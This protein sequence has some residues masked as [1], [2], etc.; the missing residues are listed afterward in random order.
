MNITHKL[1]QINVHTEYQGHPN[2]VTVVRWSILYSRDGFESLAFI[3]TVLPL[4]ELSNFT[5]IEQLQ[6]EQI[7][8]WC[9]EAQ[10]GQVFLDRLLEHHQMQIEEKK[11]RAGVVN[12]QGPLAFFLESIEDNNTGSG[13]TIRIE[14]ASV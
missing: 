5:P 11:R 8:A 2:V 6:K 13:T 12:Y 3:D 14:R 10:G 9:I 4:G 7:I 1:Y